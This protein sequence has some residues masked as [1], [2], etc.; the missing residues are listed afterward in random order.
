MET[1]RLHQKIGW[2]SITTSANCV[3]VTVSTQW[4]EAD[5]LND[6]SEV[7]VLDLYWHNKDG[8]LIFE[9][10]TKG[11]QIISYS[12]S[13]F[14]IIWKRIT[15]LQLWQTEMGQAQRLQMKLEFKFSF[16]YIQYF[17]Y[18][19]QPRTFCRIDRLFLNQFS[20]SAWH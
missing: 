20:S 4:R 7:Q 2:D 6:N 9:L 3:S 13:F 15:Y 17:R 19:L 1:D 8:S 12:S 16:L 10:D 11:F 5:T 18:N 14:T